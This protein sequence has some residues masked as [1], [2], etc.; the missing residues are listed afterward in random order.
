MFR[1]AKE[2]DDF[3]DPNDGARAGRAGLGNGDVKEFGDL[4]MPKEDNAKLR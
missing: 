4:K 1:E 2:E 3:E